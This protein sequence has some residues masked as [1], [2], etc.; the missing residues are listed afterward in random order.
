M[1]SGSDSND[2]GS[3][4]GSD[5]N[6]NNNYQLHP[7]HQQHQVHAK[8]CAVNFAFVVFLPLFQNAKPQTKREIETAG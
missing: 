2:N 5:N 8:S 6:S 3:D 4:T 7:L 1:N